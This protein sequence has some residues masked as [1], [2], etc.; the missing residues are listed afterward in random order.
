MARLVGVTFEVCP[1][2]NLQ[3]GVI[4]QIERHP[5]REMMEIGLRT[6]LNTDDPAI[7]NITLTD[8]YHT[9]IERLG[10]TIENV[11]Q[12]VRHAAEASFL[13]MLE[14]ERLAVEID[15]TIAGVPVVSNR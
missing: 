4:K 2:S 10:I 9:A 5:I 12:A 11:R 3:S 6:T 15:S 1:T 14:R 7:S 13:P 8:E